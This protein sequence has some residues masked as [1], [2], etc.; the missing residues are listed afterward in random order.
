[1]ADPDLVQLATWARLLN[2]LGEAF[3]LA[4]STDTFLIEHIKQGQVRSLRLIITPMIDNMCCQRG[5]LI[6]ADPPA[7]NSYGPLESHP[8]WH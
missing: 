6:G 3:S 8:P 4:Y 1:M 7:S 2:C 5:G